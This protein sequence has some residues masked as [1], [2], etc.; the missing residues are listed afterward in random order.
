MITARRVLLADDDL[1]VR[2]GV[3]DLLSP[4]GL[5]I[6]HAESGPETFEIVQIERPRLDLMVLDMHMPGYGGLEVLSRLTQLEDFSLPCICCSGEA[7]DE[8]ERMALAAGA[9]AFLTK[10][11]QPRALRGEVMR[12][13]EIEI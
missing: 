3:A 6:L 11:L 8:L 13:L 12:A 9:R 2:Q 5:E 7:T 10:P 1:E 4:L